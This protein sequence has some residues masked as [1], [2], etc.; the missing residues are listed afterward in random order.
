MDTDKEKPA[1]STKTKHWKALKLSDGSRQT[2]TKIVLYQ[3][4][5]ECDVCLSLNVKYEFVRRCT[6]TS[7]QNW[8]LLR[9]LFYLENT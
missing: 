1:Y 7:H 9:V 8:I 4:N 2:S 3:G 6:L 5:V